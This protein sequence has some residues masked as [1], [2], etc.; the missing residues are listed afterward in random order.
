MRQVT[1]QERT[2]KKLVPNKLASL[3]VGTYTDIGQTGLQ[4]RITEKAKG[5]TRSWLLRFKFQGQETRILLGHF[6]SMSLDAARGEARRLRELAATGIDPRKASKRR[7]TTQSA[8]PVSAA[9]V[10]ESDRHT[11][12]FLCSEF[13]ERHV[14]PKRKRPEYVQAILLREVLDPDAW[15]GR[16]ARTIKPIEVIEL[17]DGIVA[18]GSLVMANRVAAV[19]TQ[20]F[21]FGIHRRVVEQSPVMLLYRPGGEEKSRDRALSDTELKAFLAASRITK[22]EKLRAAMTI[23][24]LTGQRRGELAAAKWSD[25]DFRHKTWTIPPENSKTGKGHVV[26]LT[27]W[28]CEEFRLLQRIGT[29]KRRTDYVLPNEDG[30][31]PA[32]AKLLT[33]GLARCQKRF[34]VAGIEP[35]TLHDLRRTCRTGLGR[36]KVESHIAERVLNHAQETDTYDVHDYL[37]EKREALTRWAEHL[38]GLRP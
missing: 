3:S 22:T 7:R 6:P 27:A 36:L 33:R 14:K 31:Q 28:A 23:L 17:L 8:L 10:R 20:L 19:L 37:A 25:I 13:M 18:R 1:S 30:R 21:K 11:I 2:Q 35:F 26:P 4:F 16:D 38:E 9:P 24:L 32:D 15:A 29:R 34:K 5:T 12:E